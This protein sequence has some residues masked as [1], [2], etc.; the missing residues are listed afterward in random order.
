MAKPKKNNVFKKTGRFLGKEAKI[1]GKDISK[2]EKFVAK[3]GKQAGKFISEEEQKFKAWQ[4]KRR[5][6]G[7]KKRY[8][9][10]AEK[11]QASLQK[12]RIFD[13]EQGVREQESEMRLAPK[14]QQAQE[15]QQELALQQQELSGRLALGQQ[16]MQYSQQKMEYEQQK[17]QYES[18]KPHP[19]RDFWNQVKAQRQQALQGAGVQKTRLGFLTAP[20]Q[21]KSKQQILAELDA[22]AMQR[23]QGGQ[24]VSAGFSLFPKLPLPKNFKT[25][26]Q[27]LAELDRKARLR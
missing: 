20:P 8:A 27:I 21:L 6:E 13:I 10:V 5:E 2:A 22:R 17:R 16:Q 7:I 3:K 25:N 18:S 4:A 19:V 9:T 1:I 23:A 24:R 26:K 11:Q 14:V 15:R 12:K